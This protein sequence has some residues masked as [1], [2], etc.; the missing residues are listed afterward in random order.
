[1]KNLYI[2]F[3]LF[4]CSGE[5]VA[6]DAGHNYHLVS[7]LNLK[8]TSKTVES[9]TAEEEEVIKSIERTG[10][11]LGH[12]SPALGIYHDNGAL[13]EIE[14]TSLNIGSEDKINLIQNNNRDVAGTSSHFGIGVR[15]EY[16][17]PVIESGIVQLYIGGFVNPTIL[18]QR[19]KPEC[20]RDPNRECRNLFLY[21]WPDG[22][23]SA[24]CCNLQASVYQQ[25]RLK[26]TLV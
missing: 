6:Q 3:A 21:A 14:L 5:L 22:S 20:N 19:L 11:S 24:V 2:L 4:F 13:S 15:Y 7:Y 12:F 10:F 16:D 17:Y 26:L 18:N 1:M 23:R 8:I 9:V 25:S